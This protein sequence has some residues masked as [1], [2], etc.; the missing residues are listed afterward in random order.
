MDL[1]PYRKIMTRI[2]GRDN[3]IRGQSSFAVEMNELKTIL[4]A[5]DERTLVLGDELCAGTEHPSA[6]AIVSASLRYLTDR[7]AS[8]MLATHLHGLMDVDVLKGDETIAERHMTVV[9]NAAADCLE[10]G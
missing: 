1:V 2:V 7:G 6:M 8:T 5:A 3:M 4:G 10:Y 9:F